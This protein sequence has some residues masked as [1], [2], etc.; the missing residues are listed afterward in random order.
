MTLKQWRYQLRCVL[1]LWLGK[2]PLFWLPHSPV[3]KPITTCLSFSRYI[4][5]GA[6]LFARWENWG[7]LDGSY[8]CFISLSTIGFGDIVPGDSI[9]QSEV[10]QISFILTAVYLMLGM[11]LIAMC[12]NLMQE[13][14]IHKTRSCIRCCKNVF[15]CCVGKYRT[16]GGD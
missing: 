13:E 3:S 15:Y 11:A 8:F 7:F 1:R 5:G 4:C 6:L 14:V 16:P 9:I 10:I 12:F 2:S